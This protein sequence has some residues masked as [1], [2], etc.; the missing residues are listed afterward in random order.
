VLGG[1]SGLVGDRVC[2]NRHHGV[3]FPDSLGDW[4]DPSNVRRVWRQVRDEAQ[5]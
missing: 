2:D 4:H 3:V 5:M 1:G